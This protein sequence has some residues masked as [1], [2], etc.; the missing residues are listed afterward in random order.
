MVLK[1]ASKLVDNLSYDIISDMD[2][3]RYFDN[4]SRVPI[5]DIEKFLATS[6]RSIVSYRSLSRIL[7]ISISSSKTTFG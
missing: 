4:L 6:L 2:R 1:D 3:E 5:S 7:F